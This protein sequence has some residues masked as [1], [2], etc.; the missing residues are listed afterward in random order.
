MGESTVSVTEIPEPPHPA[1]KGPGK[2]KS[3]QKADLEQ[4]ELGGLEGGDG[5]PSPQENGPLG[6]WDIASRTLLN[7]Q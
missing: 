2:L 4:W 6:P 1:I 5:L 7:E 3:S